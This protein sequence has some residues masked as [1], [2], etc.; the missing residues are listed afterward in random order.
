MNVTCILTQPTA[1]FTFAS[2]NLENRF[3]C[4]HAH[5]FVINYNADLSYILQSQM[6]I[7]GL[8]SG[9]S[10]GLNISHLTHRISPLPPLPGFPHVAMFQTPGLVNILPPASL[11]LPGSV[12]PELLPGMLSSASSLSPGSQHS[13]SPLHRQSPLHPP[14]PAELMHRLT[15]DPNV[16]A[17]QLANHRQEMA[18]ANYAAAQQQQRLDIPPRASPLSHNELV[19][20]VPYMP[21]P[22]AQSRQI[23]PEILHR[24]LLGSEQTRVKDGQFTSLKDRESGGP[25]PVV[26]EV[27]GYPSS[28]AL[29]KLIRMNNNQ[30]AVKPGVP[31]SA[32]SDYNRSAIITPQSGDRLYGNNVT[33]SAYHKAPSPQRQNVASA[34][35][36]S[37]TSMNNVN[38]KQS[39]HQT[40]S[41]HSTVI[42]NVHLSHP[43]TSSK[44]SIP[45]SMTSQGNYY[46]AA[47]RVQE[48]RTTTSEPRGYST[49]TSTTVH[50]GSIQTL[51]AFSLATGP[52]QQSIASKPHIH[53]PG[54]PIIAQ[55]PS[56]TMQPITVVKIKTEKPSP[57]ARKDLN[58][59]SAP[60]SAYSSGSRT[61]HIAHKP[62]TGKDMARI[63]AAASASNHVQ[64][65]AGKDG[66]RQATFI[67]PSPHG[68]H[69][70]MKPTYMSQHMPYCVK[71]AQDEKKPQERVRFCCSK[72]QQL[73]TL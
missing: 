38:S 32:V 5:S 4:V 57:T 68:Y 14:L 71:E 43:L 35:S 48:N 54:K 65:I 61:I 23:K 29:A 45:A 3:F 58:G 33:S 30:S 18:L 20:P 19:H 12:S 64:P 51:P 62:G 63:I 55:K 10:P 44:P 42:S 73:L 9:P 59:P 46:A 11:S 31:N 47:N 60:A 37:A 15:P 53:A 26:H 50:S 8:S 27:K 21:P 49:V 2:F 39:I 56:S 36:I 72:M 70:P 17:L 34:Y 52:G 13:V 16:L 41:S 1:H 40:G 25:M 67:A 7:P 69:A 66:A 24:E 28:G 22:P 6:L